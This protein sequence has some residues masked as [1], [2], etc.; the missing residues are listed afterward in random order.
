MV[1]RIK[2]D[3]EKVQKAEKKGFPDFM[4]KAPKKGKK[5]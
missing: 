4:K 1:K 5:R 3:K 2:D